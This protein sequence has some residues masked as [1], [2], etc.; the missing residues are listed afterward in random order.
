VRPLIIVHAALPVLEA[1]LELEPEPEPE[2]EPESELPVAVELAPLPV[3]L[4]RANVGVLE[5]KNVSHIYI[6]KGALSSLTLVRQIP[7]D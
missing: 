5:T 4:P 2:P 1:E 3:A 6:D 7:W